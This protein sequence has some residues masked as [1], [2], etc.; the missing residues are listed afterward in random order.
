M[1]RGENRPTSETE[2][3]RRLRDAPADAVEEFV[4][5]YASRIYDLHCW[6]CGDHTVAEDLTQETLIAVCRDIHKFRGESRLSTWVHRVARNIAL[7][8]LARQRPES[9]SLEE[10]NETAAPQD[11]ATLAGRA[12]LRD[13]VRQALGL[14]PAAQRE[15]V[16]LHCLQGLSHSETARA[17]GRP[18]GTVKWQI[19]QGLSALRSALVQSGAMPDEV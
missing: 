5:V 16:V 1:S 6:L 19:A 7:R 13:Q 8:H 18:L 9:V 15:A 4:R 2:L 17:L 3:I 11:T 12:L 10:I 14:L